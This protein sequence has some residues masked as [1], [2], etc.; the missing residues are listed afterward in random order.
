MESEATRPPKESS[1]DPPKDRTKDLEL[2]AGDG[3]P[4]AAWRFQRAAWVV[5][6]VLLAA[7]TAGLF[8]SGPLSDATVGG[9]ADGLALEYERFG[10]A[11]SPSVLRLRLFPG[12]ARDGRAVVEWDRGYIEGLEIERITPPPESVEAGPRHLTYVF[13]ARTDGGETSVTFFVKPRG[14]GL[15]DGSVGPAGREP[16]RFR[17]CVYP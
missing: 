1:E 9:P 12:S 14:A 10:R 5:L 2:D 17:Q 15:S 3:L 8:G 6:A 13:R 16:L 11:G 4:R 7:A